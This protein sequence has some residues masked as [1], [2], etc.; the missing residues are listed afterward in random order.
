MGEGLDDSG[1]VDEAVVVEE[2]TLVDEAADN[3]KA[4]KAVGE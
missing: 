1:E 2:T 4:M 3:W